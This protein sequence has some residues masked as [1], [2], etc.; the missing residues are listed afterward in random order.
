MATKLKNLKVHKV[1]FVDAGA[2]P[3]AHIG[4]FKSKNRDAPAA[5]AA[6]G[7]GCEK[8]SGILKR[9]V[10]FIAKAAGMG[11]EEIDGAVE[12]IQKGDSVSFSEKINQVNNRKIADEIW[13]MC[14]ALQSSLCSILYDEDLDSAGAEAA[15]LESLQEF[16]TVMQVS[17]KQWACRKSSNIVS[18][19][20]DVS[21]EELEIMKAAAGRLAGEIMKAEARLAGEIMK[22][23]ARLAGES[24]VVDEGKKEEGEQ[25]M[26]MKIDKSKMTPA[27]R[28]FYDDIEKRCG[29]E[30]GAAPASGAETQGTG[31]GDPAAAGGVTKSAAQPAAG[32]LQQPVQPEAGTAADDIYKGLHP[33]VR[34]ELEGLKKFREAAEDRELSEVAKKYAVIG[35]KEEELVPLLK[36][37]KAAGGTAY[38]DML[39][40]LDQTVTMVEKSGIFSEIGKSGHG[41]SGTGSAEAKIEGIAKGYMEKDPALSYNAAIAKAWENNP[42]IL[43]EYDSEAGF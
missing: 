26:G 12:E 22:A 31:Q 21:G 6:E 27:E 39:A 37:L 25:S 16:Q 13:D 29:V 19:R 17:V 8:D 28:A 14:Y 23:E 38:N 35:K 34:A 10:A 43:G 5:G 9:L 15:M 24:A 40:M 36:S 42:D 41:G 33:A 32:S 7:T 4:L 18:K 2:N 30:E 1:D 3:D 11:Q 20:R